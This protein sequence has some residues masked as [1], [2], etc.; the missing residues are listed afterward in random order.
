MFL[1]QLVLGF[2]ENVIHSQNLL[3]QDLQ[4]PSNFDTQSVLVQ[5]KML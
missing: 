1:I 5:T 4:L 3:L 2:R